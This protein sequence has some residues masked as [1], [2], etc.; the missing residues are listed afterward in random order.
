MFYIANAQ[1]TLG[2]TFVGKDVDLTSNLKDRIEFNVTATT[3]SVPMSSLAFHYK[4]ADG[5]DHTKTTNV[6]MSAMSLGWRTNL[7]PNGKYEIWMVGH[8]KT[9]AFDKVV[10]TPHVTVNTVN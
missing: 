5:V 7:G 4:G 6:V 8:V 9:N 10:E 3:S 2:L 1:P